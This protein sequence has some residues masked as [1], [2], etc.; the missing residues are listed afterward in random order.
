MRHHNGTASALLNSY[1]TTIV[2]PPEP[3]SA[4]RSFVAPRRCLDDERRDDVLLTRYWSAYCT[5]LHYILVI[6]RCTVR[7]DTDVL[8]LRF[9]NICHRAGAVQCKCVMTILQYNKL[10]NTIANLSLYK[11]LI[12][13]YKGIFE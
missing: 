5:L 7:N 2:V 4:R 6:I 11:T 3:L 1:T 13:I 9:L 8:V 12:Y 10:I